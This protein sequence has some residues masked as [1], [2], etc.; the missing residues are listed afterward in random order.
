MTSETGHKKENKGMR[1]GV[2]FAKSMSSSRKSEWGRKEEN[3]GERMRETV[4]EQHGKN[5]M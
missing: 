5:S 1:K 4:R 3:K 2:G